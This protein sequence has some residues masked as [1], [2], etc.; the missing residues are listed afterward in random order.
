MLVQVLQETDSVNFICENS[1]LQ[2]KFFISSTSLAVFSLA[3]SWPCFSSS[4]LNEIKWYKFRNAVNNQKMCFRASF[5]TRRCEAISV[6][7]L[8]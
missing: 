8:W 2:V 7:R 3:C 5:I 6:V 4:G 1:L